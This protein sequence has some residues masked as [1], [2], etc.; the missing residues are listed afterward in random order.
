MSLIGDA[1]EWFGKLP[2][3]SIES[4]GNLKIVFY[5]FYQIHIAKKITFSDLMKVKQREG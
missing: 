4:L 5:T 1:L 2:H 3:A